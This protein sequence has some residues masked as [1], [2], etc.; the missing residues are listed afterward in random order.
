MRLVPIAQVVDGMR[1]ARAVPSNRAD[2]APL[3]RAGT[4]M[5]ADLA[6]RV[7]R[8]GMWAIWVD[9]DLGESI[10]PA[11]EFPP[12]TIGLAL[13]AVSVLFEAA[14]VSRRTEAALD[15]QALR[16]LNDAAG[17]LAECV[18]EY[19]PNACP[20]PDL[21]A[22]DASPQW[23]AVRVALLGTFLGRASLIKHGWT[24]H[25]GTRRFDRLEER[26]TTLATGLLAHDVGV[27][28]PPFRLDG[29]DTRTIPE[30][31]Q[32]VDHVSS[33]AELFP[34]RDVSAGIRVVIQSH[35][36]RWDGMGYPHRRRR[37]AIPANARICAVADAYDAL[38]SRGGGSDAVPVHCAVATIEEGAGTRFD[39]A[40]VAHFK[41]L[42]AP[43][44]V[45]HSLV[46]PDGRAAVVAKLERNDR[47][48]PTVR[49]RSESGELVELIADLA[50]LQP[51][52][53][54]A[55]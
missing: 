13:N 16:K 8:T 7:G 1:L 29:A 41:Q 19:P 39:P 20:V 52:S 47:L 51:L 40:T 35:H 25:E 33:G 24:D 45:G 14:Q 21:P 5:T 43:Y 36:E 31:E 42:V 28:A 23:H 15:A 10:V 12:D 48:Q 50:A 11:P 4:A 32:P 53:R 37:D 17:E 6:T 22:V 54:V 2:R 3:L 34:P 30:S 49:L 46:L 38:I 44:P 55:A 26:L 18:L 9:D 27:P